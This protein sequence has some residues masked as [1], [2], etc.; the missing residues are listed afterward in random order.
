MLTI[1]RIPLTAPCAL[2]FCFFT[3]T[4][5]LFVGPTGAVDPQKTSDPSIPTQARKPT[6]EATSTQDLN[7]Q[8]IYQIALTLDIPADIEISATEGEV[9]RVTLERYTQATN[10]ARDTHMQDY[11]KN[12]S[13]TT[14]QTD[15][16]LQIGV[17]LPEAKPN[18]LPSIP[19]Q[20][21]TLQ[22]QLQVKWTIKTPP[23]V[24]VKIQAKKGDIHLTRIR[25]KIEI[26]TQKGNVQLDETAGT[27]NVTLKKGNIDGKILLTHG[28]NTL[29][30]QDG[31]IGL[32]VLDSVTAPADVTAQGGSVR[33]E[34]PENY[35]AD[36]EI[37]SE[38]EQVVINLPAEIDHETSL[39]F[40]NGG[41]PLLRLK[42]TEAISILPSTPKDP[43]TPSDPESDPFAKAVQ[44]VPE[45]ARP[46][47]IDG[48]LSEIAWHKAA[49][50]AP[51]QNPE[52][53]GEPNNPTE[54]LLMWDAENLYIGIKASIAEAQ[55][56]HIS[57]TQH[58]SP[59]WEDECIEILMDPN[60][61]TDTYYHLVINPIGALFDQQVNLPG[62]PD[63]QFAPHD[64]QLATN[65]QTVE[66]AFDA[67][68]TWNS[69]A[70]VATE[71][72]TTFWSI[73]VALP[74]KMLEK[75]AKSDSQDGSAFKNR[76]LFNI[77]RKAHANV[78]STKNL[79][80]WLFNIHRKAHGN[81]GSTENLLPTTERE[82]SC[83]LPTYSPEY[84]WWTHAPH[85]Y[86]GAL[87]KRSAPAMGLLR[88]VTVPAIGSEDFTSEEKFQ[89]KAIEIEGNTKI[90]TESIQQSMPIQPGDL[91]T[92]SALS[93]L[94]AELR[95]HD[96]FQDVRV[97]TKQE[98]LDPG[99]PEFSA[100]V[101][102]HI[103]VTEAPVVLA[104]QVKIT[105]NRSFPAR[106]IKEWF[107]LKPGYI[108]LATAK[109]KQQLIADFYANRGYEFATVT[110][111]LSNDVLE[112]TINEGTLH[113]IRFTGNARISHA[114]LL[115]ALDLKTEN[116]PDKRG[117]QTP[118][119]YHRTLGQS[120]VNRMRKELRENNEHF[121]SV[122]E[123]RV[124]REGG[125]NVMIVEIEEQSF[126]TPGVFPILQ[127]NRVHGLLLGAGGTLATRLTGKEQVFAAISRG[128]SSKT[129]DYHAGLEKGFF[130]RQPLKLG[131]SFYKLTDVSSNTYLHHGD[132]SLGAAY[133]GFD[134]QD[135]YE[136]QGSQGWG[137]PRAL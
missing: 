68:S 41:G 114:E 8:D 28:Q 33:L 110:S 136:R 58:D 123:W 130:Q 105:G 63:F 93:W 90:A 19:D 53:T 91:I 75:P 40:I 15:G 116:S 106:F 38:K 131:G 55:F 14:A 56:P 125:K 29:K 2:L 39:T 109:L 69:G 135:Y 64:V 82:Y 43:Q 78:A 121:K 95:N 45:T 25:G 7:F 88:L 5:N 57:Q 127:F 62:D 60:I 112:F 99:S 76:W 13:L 83:W 37:Q 1:G 23:D 73:E 86:V 66:T 24:S 26:A 103:H 92:V 34:L 65:W 118:D 70:E 98:K 48:N 80:P 18:P 108:A 20:Q 117:S 129:W 49:V 124:Q 102:V 10:T 133:Y 71:I 137:N 89:V 3:L 100:V 4:L 30:T 6:L 85:E 107:R 46:P 126:V 128:F 52:G 120:K 35:A 101:S 119:I 79:V 12:I 51:F 59:I 122:R 111:E 32:T 22:E 97:E 21:A 104:R 94:I 67:D 72:N 44:P 54:T 17:Q 47:I 132:A 87:S 84:P 16:T 31:S 134:L 61:S 77:H 50:L 27:Y 11:L 36:L 74:R 113:E 96:W 42:A 81:V 9:I 115:A